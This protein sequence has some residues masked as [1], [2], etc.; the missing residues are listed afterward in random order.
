ML[1]FSGSILT[2]DHWSRKNSV[3][4]FYL[5]DC[6]EWKSN[7]LNRGQIVLETNIDYMKKL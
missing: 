7:V 1:I 5:S 3:S 2:N 4:A 6:Y